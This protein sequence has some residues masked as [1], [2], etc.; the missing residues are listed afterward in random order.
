LL[1][2]AKAAAKRQGMLEQEFQDASFAVVA[3]A[4]ETILKNST[5]DHQNRWKASPLQL[6]YFQTRNAGEELFERLARLRPE[7]KEIREVYYLCLG[8]D[9][10]G[11][12]FL[13][14]E[15]EL[16]LNQIRQEQIQHLPLAVEDVQRLEKVTPQPYEVKAPVGKPIQRPLTHLL[17]KAGV[18]LLIVVPLGLYLAYTFSKPAPLPLPPSP[19][20][21]IVE[22]PSPPPPPRELTA[23]E[24]R[25][26]IGDQPCANISVALQAGVVDLGGR[27]ASDAQRAE[28]RRVVQSVE[29]VANVR[30]TFQI[31]PH[32]LCAVLDLLEPFKAHAE[33]QALGMVVSLNKS[34]SMP[35]YLKGE[36]D[37][38]VVVKTPTQFESHVYIDYYAT[39]GGVAHLF[40][41][42]KEKM[43][44]FKSSSSYAVDLDRIGMEI[45]EPFGLELVTVI[46][47]RAPLFAVPRFDPEPAESYLNVLRQALPKEVSTSEVAATFSFIMTRDRQ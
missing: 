13:G 46:A 21:K 2:Q 26:R 47:S 18:T 6:E 39:D 10:K 11:R 16:K 24:I 23:E 8:L 19:P 9:F 27:V 14:L 17:L 15:D 40:P 28:V 20:Q 31:V 35:I 30:D 29:G 22:P 42:P 25:R 37:L 1:E 45:S 32:P 33:K 7:Q 44:F 36:R 12:Y 3:W 41:N 34:G 38:G 43:N 5:W 4:D